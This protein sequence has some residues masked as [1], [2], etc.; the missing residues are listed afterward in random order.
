VKQVVITLGSEGVCAVGKQVN[1]H[2]SALN[3]QVQDVTGAGDALIAGFLYAYTQGYM[4]EDC[5]ECGIAAATLTIECGETVD[6]H[7]TPQRL[8]EKW[9][10]TQAETEPKNEP[11]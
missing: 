7:L 5:I 11:K 3:A 4:P 1:R 2:F 9:K 6:P 8:N 10:P